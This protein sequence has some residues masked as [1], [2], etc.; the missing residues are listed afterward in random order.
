MLN[1]SP[2]M[3]R[4]NPSVALYQKVHVES[5]IEGSATPHRL[6]SMLFDGFFDAIAQSKGALKA[7]DIEVKCKSL[8]RASAIV[9]EGLRAA[10]DLK[11]GGKIARDLNDL[12]G[13]VA[14]R[15]TYA[16]LK[17]DEA[18]I[19]E[20]VKLMKPVQDAWNAIAPDTARN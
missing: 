19:D 8:G 9:E 17:N 7:K 5:Q 15:L 13:Y 20:C 3:N 10:L 14:R 18:A 11:N 12:Y 16:N 2:F 1:A 6:V 4:R